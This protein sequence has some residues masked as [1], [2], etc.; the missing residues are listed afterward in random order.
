M[1]SLI[2]L[3]WKLQGL[4][5]G[6]HEGYAKYVLDHISDDKKWVRERKVLLSICKKHH[7]EIVNAAWKRKLLV[8]DYRLCRDFLGALPRSN[9]IY[10]QMPW[11]SW[12]F[13]SRCVTKD[14]NE[15]ASNYLNTP[16]AVLLCKDKDRAAELWGDW[17][18]RPWRAV[19][20]AAPITVDELRAI[21]GSAGRVIVKP[22]DNYGGKGI[23]FLDVDS[24]AAASDAMQQ[25]NAMEDTCV[26]E[27]LIRQ[28][29]LLHELNP[30]SVNTLR[31]ITVR[32]PDGRIE[33]FQSFMRIGHAGAPVD[34]ISSGGM[35]FCVDIRS[36]VID[37]GLDYMGNVFTDHL[38][39][40]RRITGIKIPRWD[41]AV[42]YCT[43]AH[44]YAPE[45]L[46][47]VGW[48]VCISEDELYIVEANTCPLIPPPA[49]WQPNPWRA[50][51]T[52]MNEW[53]AVR[54]PEA[55]CGTRMLE[56]R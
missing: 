18:K 14:R 10:M 35:G 54:V 46:K 48:D 43:S 32:H 53:D 5:R 41:E 34:N 3:Y 44:R 30:S 23:F 31:L 21:A 7:P 1:S 2:H 8:L 40:G 37:V 38:D 29:G 22:R 33:L 4:R 45:G 28:T 47:M 50:L 13:R 6:W 51:R 15:F 56:K 27:R 9:Y 25:L 11:R 19:S 42:A 52:L 39:T 36:G 17:F 26:V 12:F 20:K 24:D 49:A 55:E 16:E